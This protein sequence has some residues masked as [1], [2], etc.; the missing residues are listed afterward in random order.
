MSHEQWVIMHW[1]GQDAHVSRFVS[2]RPIDSYMIR[3]FYELNGANWEDDSLCLIEPPSQETPIDLDEAFLWVASVT[4]DNTEHLVLT[5]N[6]EDTIR[7][8]VDDRLKNL[9]YDQ[10]NIKIGRMAELELGAIQR[11]ISDDDWLEATNY[12]RYHSV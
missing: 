1:D 4:L 9:T 3:A 8:K 5:A 7:A 2:K 12:T 11:C 10:A 6:N